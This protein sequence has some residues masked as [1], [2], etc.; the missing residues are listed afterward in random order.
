[1]GEFMVK[2]VCVFS[3]LERMEYDELE[4]VEDEEDRDKEIEG[5][6]KGIE[7]VFGRLEEGNG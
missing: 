2:N 1:M 3:G 4:M 7:E 6:N 5:R